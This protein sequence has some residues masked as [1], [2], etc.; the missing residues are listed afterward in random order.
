M[1]KLIITDKNKNLVVDIKE[2]IAI[3]TDDH[4][5]KIYTSKLT[6]EIMIYK[7]LNEFEAELTDNNFF[8]INRSCLINLFFVKEFSDS[9][10]ILQNELTCTLSRRRKFEFKQ[11][12]NRVFR[13][14]N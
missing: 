11:C 13:E 2:I 12:L 3:H 9:Q 6:Q 5:S 8:R 4:Y 14:T 7:S 10:V 1:N